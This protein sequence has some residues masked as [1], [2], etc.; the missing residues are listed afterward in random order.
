VVL[1]L[2]VAGMLPSGLHG[3]IYGVLKNRILHR[4][5]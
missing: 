2:T 5:M 1:R 4:L 3:S